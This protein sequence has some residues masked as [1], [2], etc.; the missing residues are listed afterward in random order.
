MLT[1]VLLFCRLS[2]GWHLEFQFTVSFEMI[3]CC[4]ME[5]ERTQTLRIRDIAKAA[6]LEVGKPIGTKEMVDYARRNNLRLLKG[7]TPRN[8][9]QAAVWKDIKKHGRKSP[10]IML[11]HG[12]NTR[13]FSLRKELLE[14]S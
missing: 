5:N 4:A 1:Q 11:G 8:S 9:L 13:K 6:I 2:T 10:F 14:P 12:R 3:E 7:K